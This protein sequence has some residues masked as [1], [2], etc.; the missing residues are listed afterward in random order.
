MP[1]AEHNAGLAVGQKGRDIVPGTGSELGIHH[2]FPEPQGHLLQ[3]SPHLRRRGAVIDLPVLSHKPVLGKCPKG[4][5]DPVHGVAAASVIIRGQVRGKGH[6]HRIAGSFRILLQKCP[7]N[8]LQLLYGDAVVPVG[9][10]L[11]PRLFQPVLADIGH[12]GSTVQ[13]GAGYGHEP[14][15]IGG[16]IQTAAS[17]RIID[18]FYVVTGIGFIDLCQVRHQVILHQLIQKILR[19]YLHHVRQLPGSHRQGYLTV[20]VGPVGL[21]VVHHLHIQHVF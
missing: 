5:G 15:V 20:I 19:T 9:I 4:R 12:A 17:V 8:L 16:Q 18:I 6:A 14:S 3:G 7:R 21:K 10:R 1:G 13:V 2:P 11:K